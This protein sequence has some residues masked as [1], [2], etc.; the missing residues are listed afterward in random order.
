MDEESDEKSN[1]KQEKEFHF[2]WNSFFLCV[3]DTR[4]KIFFIHTCSQKILTFLTCY[5][6]IKEE[7]QKA[8]FHGVFTSFTDLPAY[9]DKERLQL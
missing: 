8:D 1:L 9:I 7:N 5:G 2:L 4:L 3:N 6:T